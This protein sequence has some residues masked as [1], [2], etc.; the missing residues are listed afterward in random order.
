MIAS[1]KAK[2]WSLLLVVTSASRALGSEP[3]ST[4]LEIQGPPGSV[5]F[6]TEI[7]VLPNGNTVVTDPQYGLP[8][9]PASV[10]AVHL[11]AA[12]SFEL[13]STLT[14]TSENDFIALPQTDNTAID[15]SRTTIPGIFVLSDGNFLVTSPFWDH[16]NSVDV[17]AITW[18][19]GTTGISGAVSSVNSLIGSSS[20]DFR[21]ARITQL[22][23]S[24]C[25]LSL[26]GWDNGDREDAGAVTFIDRTK[27]FTGVVS[28]AN[29]LVG[30][31]VDDAIGDVTVLTN[32]NYVVSSSS[33]NN[34]EGAVGAV[35]WC[36]GEIGRVGAVTPAN[37]LVGQ[38]V[39]FPG[40]NLSVK[41]VALTNG[42]YVVFSGFSGLI[43]EGYI[44]WADGSRATSELIGTA[45]SL[46][47][48]ERS[49]DVIPLTNGNYVVSTPRLGAATFGDG[50]TG[51]S[52]AVTEGN[53]LISSRSRNTKVEALRNGN[54]VVINPD[55][56][57]NGQAALSG[58]G[59]VTWGNGEIGTSGQVTRA[60]SLTGDQLGHEVG[61]GGVTTLANGN[62]VV[63][64][65]N[66]DNGQLQ[67]AGAATLGDGIHGAIGSVALTN[68]L[69]GSSA[70]D[71]VGFVTTALPNGNY[72]VGSPDWDGQGV[73]D[74]GAAT[75]AKG[76]IGVVGLVSPS[77]SLVGSSPDDR[78][79]GT[80][81]S[82]RAPD[83]VGLVTV[84]ENGNFLLS[85]PF[86]DYGAI[87]NAG[88]VTLI[89]SVSG[90]V[91]EI[92]ATNSLVGASSDDQVG[93]LQSGGDGSLFDTIKALPGGGYAIGSPS[94]DNDG[95]VN[96]GAITTGDGT[97]S[98]VGTISVED[99]ET[100]SST[101]QFLGRDFV[102]GHLDG[103][104]IA[105]EQAQN[106]L[107]VFAISP[108]SGQSPIVSGINIEHHWPEDEITIHWQAVPGQ[109]YAIEGS[110]D[111]RVFGIQVAERI[112]PVD[113]NASFRFRRPAGAVWYRVR[114]ISADTTRLASSIEF[115]RSTN[116][117]TVHW[118]AEPGQIYAIEGSSD[119]RNFSIKVNDEFLASRSNE[120]F[121]FQRPAGD[122]IWFRVRNICK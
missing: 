42:N 80:T 11:Y 83:P 13:I 111:L 81:F 77:N 113:R 16:G 109:A 17:G 21:T 25:L 106:K 104:L 67:D 35:T 120:S 63:N 87:E 110:E 15:P 52:G 30:S 49:A 101:Q 116:Q 37:S 47:L 4:P 114:G 103:G 74:A 98:L 32:G 31:S 69:V 93:F 73:V 33:W 91:G 24:H 88:A 107:T 38:L 108:R 102:V 64:S 14:G 29:S 85:S 97:G 50:Q 71:H 44:T 20:G 92:S 94:W 12:G 121:T 61:S 76:D 112:T 1:L 117:L 40:S 66:W 45:N 8:G 54:Y 57:D 56:S 115:D 90:L 41:V 46:V 118:D 78:V 53:S 122:A 58:M 27:A 55:W 43:D 89:D 95:L 86:W 82:F 48:G 75:F 119:L 23:S 19:S 7:V 99:S 51:I 84:L 36:D 22:P 2:Y 79:G 34:G 9:G 10:G 5:A 3:V 26:P 96:A 100:G 18:V 65:P 59:A 6:G 28:S 39:A 60:N 68:S 105:R 72:V 70:R 62:Y